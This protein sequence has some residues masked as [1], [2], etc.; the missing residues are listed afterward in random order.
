M[1]R[2]PLFLLSLSLLPCLAPTSAAD[3]LFVDADLAT[4]ANDGSS[5]SNAFQGSDGLQVALGVALS[6]DDIF[7]A[8]GTY[9]PT[10]GT[11]RTASFALANGVEL[12][13]GFVGTE[14]SP[15]ERPPFGTAP[16]VLDG[17]LAGDGNGPGAFLD[18][19]FHIVR[20]TGTNAT[21]VLDG[22][23]VTGGAATGGGA[24]N[25][26]GGGILC[27]GNVG[28]TVRN[29]RFV[30]NRSSF[31]GAAGYINNGGFPSF[32]DCSFED[33]VG[34]SFGGAF[35]IAGGNGVVFERCFFTGNTAGRAGALEIFSSNNCVVNNCVFTDNTSTG[36]GGTGGGGLWIG[37]GGDTEV[38]NCTVVGNTSV[39]NNVGG[40]RIQNAN[41][42][43]VRNCVIWGNIGPASATIQQAQM[44]QAADASY[45]LVEGDA[46]VYVGTGNI[47]I[48]PLFVDE[49]GGDFA[50]S[51]GS[52]A[53]D[54]ADN[55]E[56]PAG[57]T[58]DFLGNARFVDDAGVADTGVGPAPVVD[59]GAFEFAPAGGGPFTDLGNSLA[60][61]SGAPVLALS[62]PLTP[63][64]TLDVSI[65]NALPGSTAFIVAGFTAINSPLK[66]GVLVPNPDV[67]VDLPTGTGDLMFGATWPAGVPSA[68]ETYYQ[69]W[70]PDVGGPNGFAV[71]NAI[72]GTTP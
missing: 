29:C 32:T 17:D 28:P 53:I 9:F 13:G 55:T 63:L 27:L 11:S 1:F 6:D 68:F 43:T 50:L 21:A 18:N 61:T 36:N 70:V 5:W 44:N 26:R 66:G 67:L 62:G 64:S 14:A 52:P 65:T 47:S 33:G 30:E 41:Q 37:S 16:S 57:T 3:T 39:N 59:M 58:V 4:G 42:T 51:A 45:C 49:V 23:T 46:S 38:R 10:T 56:V 25:D 8:E 35:D 20:T 31:G 40:L 15:S 12:F 60:G 72:L 24:N 2:P 34:G 7:V 19:S 69:V 22:F 71:S 48:D 54:A